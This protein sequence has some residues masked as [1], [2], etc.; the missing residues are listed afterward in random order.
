MECVFSQKNSPDFTLTCLEK[1]DGSFEIIH[2]EKRVQF[3]HAV[4]FI[5]YIESLLKTGCDYNKLSICPK[6]CPVMSFKVGRGSLLGNRRRNL[7]ARRQI[8]STVK[9]FFEIQEAH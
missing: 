8:I 2:Q 9:S 7:R 3:Q 5:K 1:P 4:N 6:A